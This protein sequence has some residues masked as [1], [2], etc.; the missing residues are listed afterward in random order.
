MFAS[1]ACARSAEY[2]Y[3][4]SLDH[5]R[6]TAQRLTLAKLSDPFGRTL[7]LDCHFKIVERIKFWYTS[8]HKFIRVRFD[9][10]KSDWFHTGCTIPV[11]WG[12]D[13]YP[14]W[15]IILWGLLL[16]ARAGEIFSSTSPLFGWHGF[17]STDV[18]IL[19]YS[20]V[21]AFDKA[22]SKRIGISC[23]AIK[24]HSRRRTLPSTLASIPS[25]SDIHIRAIGRWSLAILAFYI[26]IPES[27]I[28]DLQLLTLN[29]AEQ[30]FLSY[31]VISVLFSNLHY[32]IYS[33][34]LENIAKDQGLH[35]YYPLFICTFS[36]FY[37]FQVTIRINDYG[38][39]NPISNSEFSSRTT[40]HAHRETFFF[41]ACT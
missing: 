7:R 29:Y 1:V 18:H 14:V 34:A 21:L 38:I 20:T 36:Y 17:N 30:K 40:F 24:T 39:F 23:N 12:T 26:S 16:C 28:V 33:K 15:N 41:D 25:V 11:T 35:T 13:W 31:S 3:K 19:C 6:S 2:L 5:E 9:T 27:T 10:H 32:S 4:R 8:K 22:R 37:N